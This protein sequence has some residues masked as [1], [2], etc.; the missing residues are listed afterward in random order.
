MFY[1]FE[2]K[3]RTGRLVLTNPPVNA[4][5]PEQYLEL[6]QKITEFGASG[7]ID[8]MVIHGEGKGYC[9]GVD[10]KR[11]NSGEA[12]ISEMNR[13]AFNTFEAI[14]KAEI[15]VIS[16]VHG[17]ALGAGLA[18]AGA[19][20]I[21]VAAQGAKFGLPEIKVGLLGGASHALRIL[22][23]AKVRAMYYTGEPI[24]ADEMHRLGAVECVVPEEKMV[25]TA[26]ELASTIAAKDSRG[27]RFA[28]EAM[29]GI[30]PVDLEKNYRFEQGFTFEITQLNAAQNKT[31]S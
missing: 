11:L 27:L 12:S 9:A 4:F 17:Y 26:M 18:M 14:H 8:V 31:A 19:S 28:K 5:A 3:D 2:V 13:G 15:P 25:E 24:D 7:D 16:A 21:I 23:L 1:R 22:P 30:E 20:D 6:A 10:I 29:N